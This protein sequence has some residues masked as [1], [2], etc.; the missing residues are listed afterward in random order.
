[1]GGRLWGALR[2]LGALMRRALLLLALPAGS[3]LAGEPPALT[4]V[5][6]S[7]I[8]ACLVAG[9]RLSPG[10]AEEG[11]TDAALLRHIAALNGLEKAIW[12]RLIKGKPT[13]F[14][15]A[16]RPI[17]RPRALV[18]GGDLTDDG[19]GQL[20]VPGEGRQLQQFA[21]RYTEGK[22]PD[23]LHFPVYLGLGNH[24]LDQDGAA[25]NRDWYRREMRDYV[26]MT[27]R[28][29]V[30]YKAPT[31]AEDYDVP[32]DCYSFDLGRLHLVQL[33][34]FGGDGS[35]GAVSCLDWLK[36]DL[37]NYA[38]DGRPVVLF[39]HYGWDP[40]SIEAWDPAARQFDDHGPGKPHWW[41]AEER[42]A[43]LAVLKPYSVA[44]IFHGHE[45]DTPMIYRQE[46][47]DLFKPIAA[48]K[49]GFALVRFDGRHFDVALGQ[50]ADEKGG[51]TF[52]DGFSRRW[53]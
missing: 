41:S 32:S 47:I 23:R 53:P 14:A 17:G 20:K 13:G 37:K 1:M 48:F 24:D 28:S 16:G 21:S 5:F 30:F 11:K 39:Q 52:T 49:G 7:D 45:H 4:F 46:G 33:H 8:H 9:D 51:I 29:S 15:A 25:P 10:C 26:E 42:E 38:A 36:D 27:H 34:R 18:L 3:A 31:P 50:A 19:G 40:F 44:G 12:P 2:G 6:A 35:H 43:L 22:G